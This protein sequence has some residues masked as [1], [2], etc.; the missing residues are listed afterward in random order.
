MHLSTLIHIFALLA[1]AIVSPIVALPS[2]D[3]TLV[4]RSA[5]SL[6]ARASTPSLIARSPVPSGALKKRALRQKPLTPEEAISQQ[7]CPTPMRV[8][9][10]DAQS[11]P[12]TLTEWIRDGFECVDTFEDLTSCGGCG[13]VD[14]KYDCTAIKGAHAVSC[15]VGQCRIDSCTKGYTPSLDGKSCVWTY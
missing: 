8:C 5:P 1:L 6:Q 15:V 14:T 12:T 7:L 4:A 9:S 3:A 2:N 11:S 10:I 13:S